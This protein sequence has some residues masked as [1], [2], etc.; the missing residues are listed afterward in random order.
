[1]RSFGRPLAFAV[2]AAV[3]GGAWGCALAGAQEAAPAGEAAPERPRIL[4]TVQL[5]VNGSFEEAAGA[6]GEAAA[7]PRGWGLLAGEGGWRLDGEGALHGKTA[8]RMEGAAPV[9][10]GSDPAA[11][12]ADTAS[13]TA[14]AMGRGPGLS[15]SVRWLGADGAVLREDVLAAFPPSSPE[16]WTRFSLAESAPPAG[17]ARVSLALAG[18]PAEGAPCLWD[19][20]ELAASAERAPE[21]RVL[22]CRAGYELY[23]PKRF[24]VS[25]NFRSGEGGFKVLDRDGRTVYEQPLKEGARMQGARGSDWGRHYYRG[26]FSG[27]DQEG[28]FRLRVTLGDQTVETPPVTLAFDHLWHTA[29]PKAVDGLSAFFDAPGAGPLWTGPGAEDGEILALLAEAWTGVQWRIRKNYGGAALDRAVRAAAPAA[30]RRLAAADAAALPPESAAAWAMALGLC[31]AAKPPVDGAADAAAALAGR[32]EAEAAPGARA[33]TA[34][35]ALHR[36]TGEPRW[37]ALAEKWFPG[38]AP[39]AQLALMWHESPAH[40]HAMFTLSQ[41]LE[42]L[43]DALLRRADNPFGLY[44]TVEDGEPAFFPR[45]GAGGTARALLAAQTMARV[46]RLVPKPEYQ[47]FIYDQ[48]GWLFGVNPDGLCL[49][50]GIGDAPAPLVLPPPGKTREDCAGLLLNGFGARTPDDDRPWLPKA[51]SEAPAEATN[52]FSLSNSARF[53]STLSLVKAIRTVMPDEVKK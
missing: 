14:V 7:R 46:Y 27:F 53:V 1:M 18:A 8:L 24:V 48:L 51:E 49:M 37:A 44:A 9:T 17:A 22:W 38:T 13:V 39:E 25:A 19:A 50:E 2:A 33:F 4:E 12:D 5:L 52:G 45:D 11:L 42:K 36:A 23:A 47:E 32:L 30:L 43:G 41:E 15:A 21:M 3:L 26:A 29:L 10:A 40:P 16:G 35:A 20:A 34:A 6:E 28:E 31:A